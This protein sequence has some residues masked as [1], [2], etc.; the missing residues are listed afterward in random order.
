MVDLAEKR[1]H[2]QREELEEKLI[3]AAL[4]LCSFSGA[5]AIK[6]SIDGTTPPLFVSIGE[7]G[8]FAHRL[9]TSA[10]DNLVRYCAGCGQVGE[11][12][13]KYVDCCPDGGSMTVRIPRKVADQC[14]ATFKAAIKTITKSSV[15]T[16]AS[17]PYTVEEPQDEDDSAMVLDA[18][19]DPMTADEIVAALNALSRSA[20]AVI[21][22]PIKEW[23]EDMGPV[24]WWRLPVNEPPWVGTP[25]DSDWPLDQPSFDDPL[26]PY[27]THF[28]PLVVPANATDSRRSES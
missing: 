2:Q 24:T 21:A 23:H 9:P 17:G 8:S 22:R 12:P 7:D 25:N 27:Y 4:D 26:R 13:E 5:H 6:L 28:T 11:T 14:H 20:T 18:N 15:S 10:S 19:G 16:V 3:K 1:W